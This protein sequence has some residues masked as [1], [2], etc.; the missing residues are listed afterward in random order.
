MFNN[1]HFS[2]KTIINKISIIMMKKKINIENKKLEKNNERIDTLNRKKDIYEEY[3]FTKVLKPDE[4]FEYESE[5]KSLDGKISSI[6]EQNNRIENTIIEIDEKLKEMAFTDKETRLYLNEKKIIQTLICFNFDAYKHYIDNFK[7]KKT[8]ILTSTI[9][10]NVNTF[11]IQKE[12]TKHKLGDNILDIEIIFPGLYENPGTVNLED[13][14]LDIMFEDIGTFLGHTDIRNEIAR[15]SLVNDLIKYSKEK[16]KCY[17]IISVI[18]QSET[19]TEIEIDLKAFKQACE[20][21]VHYFK[22]PINK[23]NKH[24]IFF[25]Y[26]NTRTGSEV[27]FDKHYDISRLKKDDF[28]IIDNISKRYEIEH[29]AKKI[30]K[31]IIINNKY[32]NNKNFVNTANLLSIIVRN[33]KIDE[34]IFQ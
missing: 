29:Y 8:K 32:I 6:E 26:V 19:E 25:M 10:G 27:Y 30:Q 11:K 14:Y 13:K 7:K 12:L 28:K 23:S 16:R 34:E 21:L 4:K 3:L 18:L 5:V 22:I 33:N 2:K 20:K 15:Q 31:D 17:I 9:I 24:L 1:L